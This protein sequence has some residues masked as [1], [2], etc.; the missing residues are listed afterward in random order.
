MSKTIDIN[1]RKIE[2][3]SDGY[4][5]DPWTWSEDVARILGA[6]ECRDPETGKPAMTEEHWKVVKY[7]REY[8]EKYGTCPPIRMLV[9]GTGISLQRIY[10]L[11]PNGPAKG[12]CRVAGAPKPTGCV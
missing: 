7:L 1:G 3:D 11:F 2:L 8:W 12:A 5:K 10:Q 4:L 6:E 9:K